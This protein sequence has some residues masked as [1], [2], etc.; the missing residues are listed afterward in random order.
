MNENQFLSFP[1]S[2]KHYNA[3]TRNVTLDMWPQIITAADSTCLIHL[4]WSSNF[5]I[6]GTA[7]VAIVA[8]AR[9]RDR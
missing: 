3:L 4:L 9:E 7:P 1:S 8:F 6:L 5:R 2:F